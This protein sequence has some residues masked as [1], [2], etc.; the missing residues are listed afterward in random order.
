MS[1]GTNVGQSH[2][3]KAP[4]SVTGR[5]WRKNHEEEDE[6]Q[7]TKCRAAEPRFRK[8]MLLFWQDSRTPGAAVFQRLSWT[9]MQKEGRLAAVLP[10]WQEAREARSSPGTARERIKPHFTS[11]CFNYPSDNRSKSP[12]MLDERE[13]WVLMGR[14][15]MLT[16]NLHIL[17]E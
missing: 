13:V 15:H 4:G 9:R 8:T 1:L 7:T 11:S 10:S 3:P 5:S 16:I 12:H 6:T 14:W 17:W 2:F